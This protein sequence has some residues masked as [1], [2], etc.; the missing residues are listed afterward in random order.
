[1]K[2][3]LT[4]AFAF[5][6]FISGGVSA[7]KKNNNEVIRYY[8]LPA[9]RLSASLLA[10]AE[11]NNFSIIVQTPEL[12]HIKSHPIVGFFTQ[13]QVLERL[14]EGI[15]FYYE[16]DS[17][18]NLLSVVKQDKKKAARFTPKIKPP[19]EQLIVTAAGYSTPIESAP[20]AASV[21]TSEEIK[22]S[23]AK[24]IY[25]AYQAHGPFYFAT[26]QTTFIKSKSSADRGQHFMAP[27]PMLALL[28]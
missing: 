3:L 15:P 8:D 11:R 12:T 26:L 22:Y 19:E 23:G 18:T 10:V 13:E 6:V 21:V 28:I 14:F 25:I 16:F 2:H 5:L 4:V 27:M 24:N 17:T 7:Q 9:Q 20:A 1:M